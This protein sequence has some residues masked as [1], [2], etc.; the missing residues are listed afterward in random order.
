MRLNIHTKDKVVS[1]FPHSSQFLL[2]DSVFNNFFK[3][4]LEESFGQNLHDLL[5]MIQYCATFVILPLKFDLPDAVPEDP[6]DHNEE[7]HYELFCCYQTKN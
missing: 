6:D 4:F 2:E 7:V 5:P 1:V 3:Q